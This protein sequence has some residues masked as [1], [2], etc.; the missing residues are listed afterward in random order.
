MDELQPCYSPQ[1][2]PCYSH[3]TA[4]TPT[5]YSHATAMLQPDLKL[6]NPLPRRPDDASDAGRER[7]LKCVVRQKTKNAQKTWHE[8]APKIVGAQAPSAQYNGT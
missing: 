2:P 3:A 4:Q 6:A 1:T 5:C 7:R 8:F